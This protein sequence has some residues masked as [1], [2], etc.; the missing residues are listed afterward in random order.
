[1]HLSTGDLELVVADGPLT[2]ANWNGRRR[3]RPVGPRIWW[4]GDG[5]TN[6]TFNERCRFMGGE[7]STLWVEFR[8]AR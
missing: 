5:T 1:V 3:R 6:S 8:T 7:E 2:Y 4:H